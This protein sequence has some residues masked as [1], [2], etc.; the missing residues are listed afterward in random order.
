MKITV[1][2]IGG[3]KRSAKPQGDH[4]V[5]SGSCPHCEA[6]PFD[7][8][9]FNVRGKGITKTDR[10]SYYADGYC[11]K[12]DERVGMIRVKVDTIFGVE[13]DERVLNGPWKVY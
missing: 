10:D 11:L 4:V 9:P 7:A 8:K 3:E 13:E 2:I 6:E 5:V 12:C 1:E